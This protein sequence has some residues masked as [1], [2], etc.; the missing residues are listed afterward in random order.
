MT[1]E[2][3]MS[4]PCQNGPGQLP[5]R[6]GCLE[7]A[8]TRNVSPP[9]A[10]PEP[11]RIRT[12]C[13]ECV[14]RV[15][16]GQVTLDPETTH[17][18]LLAQRAGH[19]G[20]FDWDQVS[21]KVLWTEPLED[22]FGM[23]PGS[24]E[25]HYEDWAR[26]MHPEDRRWLEPLFAEWRQ[27]RI[28]EV[29]F[30][31]RIIRTDVQVRW[32]SAR[33]RLIYQPDGTPIRMIGTIVDITRLK[34]AEEERRHLEAEV[35]S[36]QKLESLATLA[37]GI[38][39]DF[40][41]LLV[42]ILGNASLVLND[43]PPD[44]PHRESLNMIE[45]AAMRAAQL[46]NKMLAYSGKGAFVV[47]PLNLSEEVRK[48]LEHRQDMLS[49]RVTLTLDL[50]DE[51]PPIEADATQIQ[52]VIFNLV[53]NAAEAIG[54]A[55]GTVTLRTGLAHQDAGCPSGNRPDPMP[56]EP[57]RVFL[58]VADTGCG[59]NAETKARV[60][61]PFFTTKFTGRGLGLAAVLGIVRGHGG[62]IRIDSKPGKGTTFT[63]CFPSM[64]IQ[65]S[66]E[67]SI[68]GMALSGFIQKPYRAQDLIERMRRVLQQD[69]EQR[70]RPA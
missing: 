67:P 39:H 40:N 50:D 15:P 28:E 46:T 3:M 12:A 62:E 9:R 57:A 51:L 70:I 42:G 68:D 14:E 25:G 65:P 22:L 8:M 2:G 5:E 37:G 38:A 10:L 35:Q 44:S 69:D 27:G 66:H 41:N 64:R 26:R 36:T 49:E 4:L 59:M 30:D 48:A 11:S 24:F 54:D 31:F 29:E 60:F 18:L 52:Q 45:L 53:T 56:A 47:G 7:I 63:L 23:P 61:D 43:L 58:E 1:T 16:A 55:R 19:V 17:R 33:A 6:P 20:V 13:R 21:G 32:V 34:R